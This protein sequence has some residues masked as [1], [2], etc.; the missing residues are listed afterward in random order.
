MGNE[1]S[2]P[3]LMDVS[4]DLKFQAKMLEK[5]AAKIESQEAANKKKVKQYLDKNDVESAKMFAENAIRQRKEA[6]NT[7]RFGIKMGAL[8]SKLESA[9]RTQMVSE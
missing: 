2:K 5:Q 8:S 7:R 3:D 9:A 4:I 6:I 1:K